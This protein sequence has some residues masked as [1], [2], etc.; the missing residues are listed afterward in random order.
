MAR[1]LCTK[2]D[3]KLEAARLRLFGTNR[4]HWSMPATTVTVLGAY[5]WCASL[6]T[7]SVPPARAPEPASSSLYVYYVERP[8][9]RRLAAENPA[10]AN[11]LAPAPLPEGVVKLLPDGRQLLEDGSIRKP[12]SPAHLRDIR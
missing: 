7:L 9:D 3:P 8:R 11:M 5:L 10:L 4:L 2:P 1:G 6:A 12:N